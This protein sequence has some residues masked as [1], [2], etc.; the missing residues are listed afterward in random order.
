MYTAPT[1]LISNF[2]WV[3]VQ[4]MHQKKYVDGYEIPFATFNTQYPLNRYLY[5]I[6]KF[7]SINH[8]NTMAVAALNILFAY[9]QF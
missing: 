1:L 6:A 7:H 5:T 4:P 8:C 2:V 3:D 9:L